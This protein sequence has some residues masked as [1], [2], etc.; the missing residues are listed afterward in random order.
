MK[1][2][3]QDGSYVDCQKSNGKII[4]LISAKDYDNPLKKIN[5]S[6]ELTTEQFQQL[7][8]DVKT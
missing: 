7:I 3:F 1:I 6:V 5:N 2:Q 4:L 8:S